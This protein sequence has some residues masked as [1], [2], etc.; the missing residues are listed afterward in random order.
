M[1]V[2]RLG[3]GQPWIPFV[4]REEWGALPEGLMED[5]HLLQLPITHVWFSYDDILTKYQTTENIR[6]VR[7]CQKEHMDQ[8]QYDIKYKYG[9]VMYYS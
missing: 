8:G 9:L 1:G 3:K 4:T 6:A 2:L 7:M 5:W